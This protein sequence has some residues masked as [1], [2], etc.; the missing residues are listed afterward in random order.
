MSSFF[1]GL[2]KLLRRSSGVADGVVRSA[3]ASI[4]D[5][6]DDTTRRLAAI[7]EFEVFTATDDGLAP[8][9]GGS[10]TEFL[11]ADGTWKSATG[12]GLVDSVTAGSSK[13]TA[14]P[15]TGAVVVDVVPANFTGIPES[16]VTGL[17]ADLAA[18]Q[19]L[20][21]GLTSLA[22]LGATAGLIEKTATDTYT[23]RLL[24]VGAGTSVPTRADAD[25]RYAA[26]G[27]IS[28]TINTVAKFT[29]AFAL[30]NSSITDSGTLVTV[31]NPLTV[32]GALQVD[33]NATIGNAGTDAHVV[34]GTLDCNHAVNIDGALVCTSTLDVTGA[35]TL[36]ALLTVNARA[37]VAG[38]NGN[39]SF[40]TDCPQVG[41]TANFS[42]N[43]CRNAGTY[44]CTAAARTAH[45]L[46][47]SVSATRSAG[48][49][50]LTNIAGRFSAGGAQSNIAIQTDNGDVILNGS[51]GVT[52]VGGNFSVSSSFSVLAVSGNVD[53]VG[54][55]DA[56]NTITGG[57]FVTSGTLQVDGNATIGNAAGDAHTVNGTVDFNHAVNI[58][59]ALVCTTTLQVDG[60]ATVGNA[61]TDTHT[62]NGNITFANAPTAG[63]FKFGSA[64]GRMLI[65]QQILSAASGTYTPT[66]GTKAV[67][68]RMVGGGGGGAGAGGTTV[69]MGTGGGGWSGTFLEKWIDAASNVTGGAYA[70]GA[71]GTAGASGA[72]NGGDGGDSTVVINGVTYTA[73]GGAK[74]LTNTPGTGT[75]DTG[76]SAYITGSSTGDFN[77]A[78]P[79]GRGWTVATSA[80]LAPGWGGSNP[81]GSGGHSVNNTAGMAAIGYG[82]GGGGGSNYLTANVAG[83]AGTIGIIIVEEYA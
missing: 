55:I 74:G 54:S 81:L 46:N 20:D 45:G 35:T 67:R 61:S 40:Q 43:I 78:G 69:A 3:I 32:T 33:G 2:R 6:A 56:D 73:K 16:G 51:S 14:S 65:A 44:N 71:A 42:S 77:V 23:E 57:A 24:G 9:S 31:T 8:A 28:G 1:P 62:L 79:P 15:T 4:E 72:N 17:V 66:T 29:S 25:A 22:G 53:T 49:N 19:P 76:I 59:G 26:I 18:K 52:S 70:C 80:F 41:G 21:A 38:V 48:A 34:N 83:G 63:T 12:T 82:G 13:V 60:N 64:N 39:D 47:A 75:T 27:S 68:V 50:N 37:V 5:W 30:G 58:D 7:R 11:S 10:A 36:S